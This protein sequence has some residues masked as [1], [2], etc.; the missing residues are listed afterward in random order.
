MK[1]IKLHNDKTLWHRWFAW[2]P[3]VVD[4]KDDGS[5]EYVWLEYVQRC[6]IYYSWIEG[7]Y[8]EW[9]YKK[10]KSKGEK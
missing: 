1:W 8:W 5:Q 3:V 9:N 4:V 6:G 2:H 10:I 7:S